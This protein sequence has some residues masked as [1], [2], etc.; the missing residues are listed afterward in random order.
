MSKW[1]C[2]RIGVLVL[3]AAWAA[4]VVAGIVALNRH[5]A[6]PAAPGSPPLSRPRGNPTDPPTGDAY[7]AM[8]AH[9]RCPCTAASLAELARVLARCGGRLRADVFFYRPEGSPDSWTRTSNRRAAESIPG[10]R[11]VDDVGG[12]EAARFGATTSGHAI[13]YGA[14]GAR[15]FSGGITAGRGHEG[16]N[17]GADAVVRLVLQRGNAAS[18]HPVFGCSI[19]VPGGRS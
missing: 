12:G 16:E 19:R 7:L 18:T 1:I 10:V 14:D 6:E 4:A 13:L 9:P 11:A 2:R 5:A 15:L 3:T 17:D 8:F